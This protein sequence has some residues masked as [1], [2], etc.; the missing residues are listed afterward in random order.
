M[1]ARNQR[2]RNDFAKSSER[3]SEG[4]ERAKSEGERAREQS[5]AWRRRRRDAAVARGRRSFMKMD[6][7]GRIKRGVSFRGDLLRCCLVSGF[8][9]FK[10]NLMLRAV[11]VVSW[12]FNTSRAPRN[13]D[14]ECERTT[15]STVVYTWS[16]DCSIDCSIGRSRAG[17]NRTTCLKV[18][19]HEY[20]T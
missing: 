5:Y 7:V 11:V 8:I 15:Y 14:Y 4:R 18:H 13:A 2:R 3:T 6:E 10:L 9:V 19:F 17:V 12:M 16:F 20:S 1:K